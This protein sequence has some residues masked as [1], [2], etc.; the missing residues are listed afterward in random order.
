MNNDNSCQSISAL[1]LHQLKAYWTEIDE[2]QIKNNVPKALHL[3]EE[4]FKAINSPRFHVDGVVKFNPLMSV[5]W[6]IF[7]YRLSNILH[8]NGGG[9]AAD[10]VY[11][12]NKIMHSIDW[13]YAIDLPVH[14][15]CEH[16]LGSVLGKASYGDYLLIYQGTTVGGSIKNSILYYP[17]F[18][19]NTVMF[20]NS[21]V[22]GNS[23]VGSNVIISAGAKVVNQDIPS[24]AIV[25]G[26]SPNLIIKSKDEEEMKI[27]IEEYWK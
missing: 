9:T 14:F 18:D 8:K 15:L 11:Y 4:D 1:V 12:L 23:H 22:L 17:V 16:P 20:A 21:S 2:T 7:L 24:N 5:H 3:M 19:G 6:M 10:Q 13:F 25:F 26:E 27:K